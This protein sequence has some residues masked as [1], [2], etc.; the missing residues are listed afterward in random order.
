MKTLAVI[1]MAGVA[2][3]AVADIDRSNTRILQNGVD[4]FITASPLEGGSENAG[5]GT[6]TDFYS[7][8]DGGS[9]FQ[10]FA[11]AD[12]I[13]GTDDY[14]STA[15]DDIVLAEFGFVGGVDTDD[16]IMFFDFFDSTGTTLVDSFGIVLGAGNFIYTITIGSEV[17]IPA[18]GIVQS[19]VPGTILDPVT[20]APTA[21][22]VLGQW[23][24][25]DAL[26]GTIIGDTLVPVS[27][28][29]FGEE[30]NHKFRL[31][32]TLVPAPASVALLGLGGFAAA[33]RRR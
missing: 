25:A 13:I 4:V 30:L 26:P 6:T 7:D 27:T 10:A 2:G 17:I 9:G 15:T 24:I 23:F 11:P 29:I 33:R 18:G 22:G 20:G 19:D 12:G 3:S 28:G 31:N 8:L 14:L 16:G 32:G 1:A 21:A 5:R